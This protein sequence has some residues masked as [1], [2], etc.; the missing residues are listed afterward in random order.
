MRL[1]AA[2]LGLLALVAVS[3]TII[4]LTLRWCDAEPPPARHRDQERLVPIAEDDDHWLGRYRLFSSH[5]IEFLPDGVFR[6]S[7]PLT[8]PSSSSSSW[9]MTGWAGERT[10]RWFRV[11][12]SVRVEPSDGIGPLELQLGLLDS[13]PVLLG[14]FCTWRRV[15]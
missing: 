3:G 15:P 6:G 11:G 7:P 14:E 1:D 8:L 9:C 5:W 4:Q 10:S 13:A 12:S 2:G